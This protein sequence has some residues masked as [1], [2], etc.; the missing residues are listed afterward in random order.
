M[1][2]KQY[3]ELKRQTDLKFSLTDLLANMRGVCKT[4]IS[5]GK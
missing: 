5:T 2:E 4:N 3:R 1:E